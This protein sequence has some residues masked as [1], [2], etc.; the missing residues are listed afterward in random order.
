[1]NFDGPWSWRSTKQKKSADAPEQRGYIER[2]TKSKQKASN[3]AARL[4]RQASRRAIRAK[5]DAPIF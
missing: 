1:M 2:V 4:R 3:K 5:N